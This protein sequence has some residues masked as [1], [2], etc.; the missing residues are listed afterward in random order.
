MTA[1]AQDLMAAGALFPVSAYPHERTGLVSAL[2][3]SALTWGWVK[4]IPPSRDIRTP[5]RVLGAKGFWRVTADQGSL[6]AWGWVA[7]TGL[8]IRDRRS[9]SS[10][11]CVGA[12]VTRSSACL[13][14]R[15]LGPCS[16]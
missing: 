15:A 13:P 9:P 16:Y 5:R 12:R 2:W 3:R 7:Q 14:G 6:G 10:A 8:N 11:A 1:Y 4:L